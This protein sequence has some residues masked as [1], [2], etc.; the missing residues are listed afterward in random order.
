MSATGSGLRRVR[1]MLAIAS[2]GVAWPSEL[3][4]VVL[5]ADDARGVRIHDQPHRLAGQ[6]VR[7]LEALAQVR[8]RAVLPHEALDPV[9]EQRIEMRGLGAQRADPGQV[10][11]VARQRR[12]AT[13]AAM[14]RAVVDLLQPGPQPRVELAPD[15]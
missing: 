7:H 13:Q 5:D 14:R 2:S 15:R 12:Q 10:T 11:L 3:P 6:L 8:H 4:A 1:L 9:V